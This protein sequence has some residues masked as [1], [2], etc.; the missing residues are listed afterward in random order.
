MK[1]SPIIL[2]VIVLW[3][4]SL[5]CGGTAAVPTVDP[6]AAQTAI[7][8]TIAAIQTQVTPTVP[9]TSTVELPTATTASTL[10]PE[11]TGTSSVPMISVS[12]ATNCRIGPG[13]QYERVGMLLVG[14]TT[15]IVGR[16]AFGQYWYVRNPSFGPPYCWISGKYAAI[17]GNPFSLPV[18]QVPGEGSLT[19]IA[20][21]RGQGKCSGE[22]WSTLRLKNPS[23]GTF[24]SMSIIVTDRDTGDV[25]SYAGN[26]FS[27]RDG[28]APVSGTS[29]IGPDGAIAISTP[30][31]PHNLDAHNMSATITLCLGANLT[32]QCATQIITYTP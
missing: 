17:T 14:A 1:K 4:A 25:R 26:E 18:Q 7:V 6:N 24:K 31:F 21:Y 2:S 32:E 8:E 30:A 27:F 11:P 28:C 5:A 15:E 3:L 16:D 9:P 22:F 29:S 10:T 23:R 13:T 20:E 12:V 19:F